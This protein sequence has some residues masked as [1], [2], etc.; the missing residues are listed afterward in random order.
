MKTLIQ[1]DYLKW[2][3]ISITVT[4]LVIGIVGAFNNL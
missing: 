3:C 2:I 1:I 4:F